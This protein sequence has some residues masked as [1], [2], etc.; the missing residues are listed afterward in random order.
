L[1]C[2]DGAWRAHGD[3]ELPPAV[4]ELR[5]FTALAELRWWHTID[6]DRGT[7]LILQEVRSGEHGAEMYP[8]L[9]RSRQLLWGTAVESRHGWTT[10]RDSRIADFVV[11][12]QNVQV[13]HRVRL[14]LIDYV[15]RDEHGN[16]AVVEQRLTGLHV[17]SGEN[18]S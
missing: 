6:F 7:A 16:V 2:A 15:T 8:L 5:A 18:L 4:F 11:P 14:E 9:S 17:D 13:G 12:I 10:L 1:N 3:R